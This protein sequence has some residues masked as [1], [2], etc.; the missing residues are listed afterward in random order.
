MGL[1]NV[2]KEY[3]DL[4]KYAKL[5]LEDPKLAQKDR[6]KIQ[7]DLHSY[8]IRYETVRKPILAKEEKYVV[9]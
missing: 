7:S 9:G 1:N 2:D 8:A 3:N 6:D 5:L 4:P